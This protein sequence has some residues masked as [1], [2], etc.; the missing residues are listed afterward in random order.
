MHCLSNDIAALKIYEEKMEDDDLPPPETE[1]YEPG[2]ADSLGQV[3]G[4]MVWIVG[5][6]LLIGGVFWL[7]VRWL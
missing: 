1:H 2:L 3:F 6:A 7:I 4:S 5:F